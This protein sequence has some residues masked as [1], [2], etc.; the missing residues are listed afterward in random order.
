MCN[1]GGSAPAPPDYAAQERE[2]RATELALA[3]EAERRALAEE[4][5]KTTAFNTAITGAQTSARQ[6]ALDYLS[7]LGYDPGLFE[8]EIGREISNISGRV[9][10]FDPAP[11]GYFNGRD[12]GD[13][14]LNRMQGDKRRGYESQLFN[15]APDGFARNAIPDTADDAILQAILTPEYE[16]ATLGLNDAMNRGILSNQGFMS[17]QKALEQQKASASSK[18]NQIGSDVL[19]TGRNS[20]RGIRDSELDRVN[21]YRIGQPELDFSGISDRIGQSTNEFKGNLEGNIRSALGG[22]QLFDIGSLIGSARQGSYNPARAP[23]AQG[24]VQAI[25]D[26]DKKKETTR[27]T[28]NSGAF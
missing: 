26:R 4:Q 22:E 6:G 1:G 18:L 27:S 15:I 19:E 7:G 20:L 2:R 13:I 14:V 5:R 23:E 3:Q 28:S 10:Q 9:P 25:A 24:L 17:A 12:I 8:T 21:N 11:G 16:K